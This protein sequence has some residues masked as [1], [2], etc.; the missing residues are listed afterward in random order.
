MKIQLPLIILTVIF[1]LG[2]ICKDM[3]AEFYSSDN[4]FSEIETVQEPTQEPTQ[5]PK[6][7][8]S[9]KSEWSS[10]KSHLICQPIETRG[11]TGE[12]SKVQGYNIFIDNYAEVL[13]YTE[14]NQEQKL[15]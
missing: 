10:D 4:Y 8:P 13:P 12:P 3:Y 2:L 15:I 7:V 14:M 1:L 6:E 9:K 5:E 11:N